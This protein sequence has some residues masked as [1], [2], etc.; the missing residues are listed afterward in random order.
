MSH[1]KP[2]NIIKRNFDLDLVLKT[3]AILILAIFSRR[4]RE[5]MEKLK[6]IRNDEAERIFAKKQKHQEHFRKRT[7]DEVQENFVETV[8][9]PIKAVTGRKQSLYIMKSCVIIVAVIKS[10]RCI[11][12]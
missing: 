6:K 4:E 2:D 10:C 1:T 7:F 9:D 5:A 11:F 12:F 3:I 8:L